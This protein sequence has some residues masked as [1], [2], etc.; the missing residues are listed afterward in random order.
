MMQ[1][2][3][4]PRAQHP[5]AQVVLIALF[6]FAV[7]LPLGLAL[8]RDELAAAN[9]EKRRLVPPPAAPRDKREV[10]T[11]PVRFEAWFNDRFGLR[12]NFI[13]WHNL[14]H[15]RWLGMPPAALESRDQLVAGATQR[16]CGQVI[17]GKEGWLFY[18][19]DH[20]L[21]DYRGTRPF[22][23]SE[24]S[25]WGR[26]FQA[27]H[28]WLAAQGIPYVVAIFPDKHTIYG[29]YLPSSVNRVSTIG[30]FDQLLEHCRLHTSVEIIDVRD[31]VRAA[32]QNDRC[33]HKYDTHWNEVGGF[34]AY[35]VMTERLA[36]HLPDLTPVRREQLVRTV[37]EVPGGDCAS[38]LGLRDLYREE[39]I[40]LLLENN[41][42]AVFE[43]RQDAG[44][45]R[46]TMKYPRPGLPRAV[47]FHD[48]Y[49]NGLMP[50]LAQH[51]SRAECY[52]LDG[53]HAPAVRDCQPHVVIQMFVERKLHMV[54]PENPAEVTAD[55]SRWARQPEPRIVR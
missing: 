43:S 52:W 33:Y 42:Q 49:F 36:L 21:E 6:A 16:L 28:D 10:R 54:T 3:S 30:R 8:S 44:L 31:A 48:S 47:I 14:A 18:S 26:V 20:A 23:A 35:Q 24:L 32:R 37:T 5:A 9:F 53:F 19:G 46:L 50:F 11:F 4:V 38:M 51:F 1:P 45:T 17:A 27:R 7:C 2:I 39:D 13:R 22:S 25:R 12:E 40:H 34:A 15:I 29:D 41:R 55:L